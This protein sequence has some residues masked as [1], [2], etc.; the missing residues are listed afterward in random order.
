MALRITYSSI[1]LGAIGKIVG[2]RELLA[3]GHRGAK[4]H[5][6]THAHDATS[7]VIE[8]Q[9]RIK[10]VVVLEAHGVVDAGG[11][12]QITGSRK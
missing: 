9:R 8:R 2:S 5:R 10:H 11:N 6:L 1:E 12:E 4:D 7:G 3:Y